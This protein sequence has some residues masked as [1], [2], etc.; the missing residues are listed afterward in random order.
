MKPFVLAAVVSFLALA[1]TTQVARA[2]LWAGTERSATSVGK[3]TDVPRTEQERKHLGAHR[4]A[5]SQHTGAVARR[6]ASA[7]PRARTYLPD[8]KNH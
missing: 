7:E 4:D 8:T 3:M 5:V 2:C 1:G 6:F